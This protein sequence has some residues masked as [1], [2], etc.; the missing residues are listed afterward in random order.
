MKEQRKLKYTEKNPDDT[1]HKMPHTPTQLRMAPALN[2][3]AEKTE[4]HRE[5]PWWHAP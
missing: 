3:G 1:L 2:E 4:V 5:N